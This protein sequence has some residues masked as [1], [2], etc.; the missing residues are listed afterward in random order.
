MPVSSLYAVFGSLSRCCC[1]WS[2][3]ID[4]ELS[5][6]F[7]YFFSFSPSSHFGHFGFVISLQLIVITPLRLGIGLWL[8]LFQILN[9]SLDSMHLRIGYA[10]LQR[11]EF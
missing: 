4:G 1:W 8:D 7:L 10:W 11:F 6:V 9:Y 3:E 5:F 2:L